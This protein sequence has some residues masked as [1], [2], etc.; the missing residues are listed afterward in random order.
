MKDRKIAIIGCGNLG[1][2]IVHG[3]LDDGFEAANLIV[4]RRNTLSLKA[5]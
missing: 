4:T 5:L 1:S 3:M 2:T